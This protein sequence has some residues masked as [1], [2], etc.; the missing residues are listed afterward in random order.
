MPNP[1]YYQTNINFVGPN[2]RLIS[3]ALTYK[4]SNNFLTFVNNSFKKHKKGR[5]I[6]FFHKKKR[7]T[8][9]TST[10]IQ[11]LNLNSIIKKFSSINSKKK[12]S[13]AR[14]KGRTS[15]YKKR[16]LHSKKLAGSKFP[17]QRI[18]SHN[19]SPLNSKKKKGKRNRLSLTTSNSLNSENFKKDIILNTEV[20]PRKKQKK[21]QTVFKTS[22]I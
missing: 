18:W 6:K 10:Q 7:Q 14:I 8:T 17:N 12:K 3:N 21:R 16:R 19:T 11:F 20:T 15:K 2:L 9:H 22:K 4:Q 5:N 1:N 13:F